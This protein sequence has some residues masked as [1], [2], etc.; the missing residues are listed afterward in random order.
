MVP[1]LDRHLIFPVFNFLQASE[2]YMQRTC[3]KPACEEGYFFEGFGKQIAS[4][5]VLFL[6]F[7]IDA[8]WLVR[9]CC[10]MLL[11]SI[12]V[13]LFLLVPLLLFYIV[14]VS[15]V[16]WWVHYYVFFASMF[17]HRRLAC[18]MPRLSTELSWLSL[19]RRYLDSDDIWTSYFLSFIIDLKMYIICAHIYI[20]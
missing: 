8:Y 17:V 19:Q 11:S 4:Q 5:C 7:V 9:Y 3:F 14:D 6:I 1:F 10:E 12:V 15:L 13:A 20:H 16:F 2:G 18:T